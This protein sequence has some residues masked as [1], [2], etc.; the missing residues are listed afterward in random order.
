MVTQDKL[1]KIH[2]EAENDK[3]QAKFDKKST[4]VAPAKPVVETFTAKN[5]N[6]LVMCPFCLHQAFL[7]SFFISNKKG[8]SQGKAECPECHNTMLMKSLW[9]DMSPTQYA[10]WVFN[11]KSMGFWQKCPFAKWK[12]RLYAIGWGFEFWIEYKRLKKDAEMES[13]FGSTEKATESYEQA[14]NQYEES[15]KE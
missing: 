3:K 6:E 15:T 11:Y 8:I 13:E 12:D 4:M 9:Q 10:Q 7:S 5:C 1:Y 2:Q 14:Y